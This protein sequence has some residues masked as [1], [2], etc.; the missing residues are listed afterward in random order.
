VNCGAK[1]ATFYTRGD[2]FGRANYRLAKAL[3]EMS[4]ADELALVVMRLAV[5]AKDPAADA[6]A[7]A[8]PQALAHEDNAPN[9]FLAW[10]RAKHLPVLPFVR[11]CDSDVRDGCRAAAQGG[12]CGVPRGERGSSVK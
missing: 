5:V 4:A 7:L 10:E 6:F 12:V 1:P 9:A 2:E 11:Y 8:C 3:A